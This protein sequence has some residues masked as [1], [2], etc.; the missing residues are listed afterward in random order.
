M[1]KFIIILSILAVISAG[2]ISC[3]KK[4][5]PAK[6][7]LTAEELLEKAYDDSLEAF[8]SNK[9][10]SIPFLTVA[11]NAKLGDSEKFEAYYL[12][13]YVLATFEDPDYE[14]IEEILTKAYQINPD[15]NF[16]EKVL[17]LSSQIKKA[18]ELDQ[19]EKKLVK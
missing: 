2:F 3:S 17:T 4:D 7:E 13:A 15:G 18:A 6:K 19:L 1:K 14:K 16:S 5:K 12:A 8:K 11:E 10:P 9:D